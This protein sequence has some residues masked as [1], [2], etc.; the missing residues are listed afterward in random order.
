MDEMGLHLVTKKS[1]DDL[2]L[3]DHDLRSEHFR[4]D[5]TAEAVTTSGQPSTPR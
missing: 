3:Q 4:A 2:E 1:R 5:K